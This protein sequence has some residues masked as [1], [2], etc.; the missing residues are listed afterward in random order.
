MKQNQLTLPALIAASLLLGTHSTLRAQQMTG[1]GANN[2]QR[3]YA[4]SAKL[5]AGEVRTYVV[6]S[7]EKAT[8]TGRKAPIEVGVEIPSTP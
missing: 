2:S 6:L 1:T 4:E 5:G 3:Y 7:K 8:E